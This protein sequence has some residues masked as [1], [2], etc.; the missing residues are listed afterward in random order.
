M[1][2]DDINN[3]DFENVGAW[4]LAARLVASFLAGLLVLGGI[5]WV[6]TKKQMEAFEL[7]KREEK[8]LKIKFEYKQKRAANL[9]QY[10]QQLKELEKSFGSMLRKLPSKTEV[11]GLLEDISNRGVQAGLHF[12]LFDPQEEIGHD[13]YLELPIKM[14]LSGTYH[15]IGRFISEVAALD[16]I[17]TLHDFELRFPTEQLLGKNQKEKRKRPKG[18]LILEVTAKTYRYADSVELKGKSKR[19]K[20]SKRKRR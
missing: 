4:P 17:V 9:E 16:R 13:F 14:S 2:L 20:K 18:A 6:D 7:V 5:Y 8:D 15:D 12:E 19:G 3:L 11:P 10:K 1:N